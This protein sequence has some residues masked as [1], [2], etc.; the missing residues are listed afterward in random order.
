MGRMITC[1]SCAVSELM[2]CHLPPDGLSAIKGYINCLVSKHIYNVARLDF[3]TRL[4][5]TVG[6][7]I[8]MTEHSGYVFH[9]TL[10]LGVLDFYG[11]GSIS[12]IRL[13]FMSINIFFVSVCFLFAFNKYSS[14]FFY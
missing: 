5:I 8:T 9:K 7:L 14:N 4:H 11:L 2:H 6:L 12:S 10:L 3:F 13:M 1:I